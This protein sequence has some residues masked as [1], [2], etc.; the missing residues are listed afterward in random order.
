MKMKTRDIAYFPLYLYL[1]L[2]ALLPLPV[3]YILAD[4][5]YFPLFS[6]TWPDW[7]PQIGGD[8]FLFFRPIFNIADTAITIGVLVILL[9][10]R[11][12]LSSDLKTSDD[13]A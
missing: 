10:Q 13:N 1:K 12:S 2:H 9:F 7:V 6:F 8:D 4:M 3:L 5:L 11:K